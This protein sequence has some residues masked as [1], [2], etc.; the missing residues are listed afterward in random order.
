[1]HYNKDLETSKNELK[2]SL[3]SPITAS[4]FQIFVKKYHFSE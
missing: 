1:M 4:L 3:R 2:S